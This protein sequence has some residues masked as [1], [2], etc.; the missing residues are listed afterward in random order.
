MLDLRLKIG[1]NSPPPA[2]ILLPPR[3]ER[4]AFEWPCVRGEV[5]VSQLCCII[6]VYLVDEVPD[7]ELRFFSS[8]LPSPCTV[9][10]QIFPVTSGAKSFSGGDMERIEPGAWFYCASVLGLIQEI[11][12]CRAV[13]KQHKNLLMPSRGFDPCILSCSR[14]VLG[15]G[16][17]N[18]THMGLHGLCSS[19]LA[20]EYSCVDGVKGGL[21]S[22]FLFE[23]NME[24]YHRSDGNPRAH[25]GYAEA[26]KLFTRTDME[27]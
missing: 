14:D 23:I 15:Q 16:D 3:D 24:S 26:W 1:D 11:D 19:I 25:M 8:V 27:C 17:R 6:V 5:S 12:S 7:L 18:F 21:V 13:V 2:E 20:L 4:V 9:S 10:T 22:Y